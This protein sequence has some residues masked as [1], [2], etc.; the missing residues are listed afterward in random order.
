MQKSQ[1]IGLR[2]AL[3]S[4]VQFAGQF[5]SRDEGVQ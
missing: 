5:V 3:L 2:T 1:E 4:A